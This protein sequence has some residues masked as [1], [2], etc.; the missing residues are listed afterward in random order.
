[1]S[2]KRNFQ[3]LN[4]THIRQL[5]TIVGCL[6]LVNSGLPQFTTINHQVLHFLMSAILIIRLLPDS[7][8]VS[9]DKEPVLGR[10]SAISQMRLMLTPGTVINFRVVKTEN[11]TFA[12]CKRFIVNSF[13]RLMTEIDSG[14][15][16]WD[17]KHFRDRNDE[18]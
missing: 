16:M 4:M 15:I 5:A 10:E 1:M 13:R 7:F 14:V 3:S 8:N 18:F 6:C 2:T 17:K 11:F 12:N 9:F